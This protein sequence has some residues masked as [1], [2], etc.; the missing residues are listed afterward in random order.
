VNRKLIALN[1]VLALAVAWAA[2]LFRNE[3]AAA[4]ARETAMRKA[5][6]KPAPPLPLPALPNQPPVLATGFQTIATRTLFHPSRDPSIPVEAPPPPPP[7]PPM[8]ALPR[9][10]GTMNIGTGPMAL[11]AMGSGPSQPVKPGDTIGPFKLVDVN[12]VDITFEWNGQIARRTLDQMTDRKIESNA[13]SSDDTRAVQAAAPAVVVPVVKQPV[14]P[15]ESTSFGF[16][17]CDSNDS[18]PDGTVKDGYRKVTYKTPF[19][20]AC[21]W[22]PVGR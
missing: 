13:S 16:K 7:P 3:I 4:K 2:Y 10:F 20:S 15:G 6:V 5:Q 22:D 19:G 1:V 12:T 21:R 18:L 14:G 9:Y 11:L 8:P 17:L